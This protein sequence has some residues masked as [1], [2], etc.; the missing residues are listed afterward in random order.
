MLHIHNGEST[1]VGDAQFWNELKRLAEARNAPIKISG[2]EEQAKSYHRVWFELTD[3][4]RGVLAGT[5]DF[6]ELTE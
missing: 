3:T 6:V 4:G 1:A 2:R 5:G